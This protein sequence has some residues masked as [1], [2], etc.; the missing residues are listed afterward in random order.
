MDAKKISD[1]FGGCPI[2]HVPGRTFPVEVRFLEDS[3]EY[4]GWSIKEGSP[5]AKR[6]KYACDLM[7]SRC[8]YHLVLYPVGDKFYRN[9]KI[10]VDWSEDIHTLDED[11][12]TVLSHEVKL[13]KRYSQATK[14]TV[15]LLDER[16]IPYDLIVRLLERL[17]FEDTS[18]IQYSAATLI[19]M[20]GLAEIR[21]LNE[22]LTEHPLFGVASGFRIFP[23]H[24]SISSENQAAVFDLP[25][26]GVRKIVIG[27]CIYFLKGHY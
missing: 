22:I 26:P 15:D 2:L 6:G 23:L 18:S 8:L 20:P 13:E 11:D 7:I 9:G 17:C 27:R 21:R 14:T 25:P 10:K 3:I 4:T 24:S 5:Y 1:F 16:L 19:F 12:D